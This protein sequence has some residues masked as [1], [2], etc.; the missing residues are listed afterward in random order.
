MNASALC[1]CPVAA[2]PTRSTASGKT[3]SA[4][5]PENTVDD[6]REV[7]FYNGRRFYYANKDPDWGKTPASYRWVDNML[8]MSHV[9]GRIGTSR[10]RLV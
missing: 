10:A 1:P 5:E 8:L 7:S 4:Q 9:S 6:Q 3:A 2:S